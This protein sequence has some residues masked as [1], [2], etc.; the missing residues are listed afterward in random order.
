MCSSYLSYVNLG[1]FYRTSFYRSL[2]RGT[3]NTRPYVKY[4]LKTQD[5]PYLQAAVSVPRE[6]MIQLCDSA[7]GAFSDL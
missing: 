3:E 6:Q 2:L 5:K 4:L 7:R 1:R